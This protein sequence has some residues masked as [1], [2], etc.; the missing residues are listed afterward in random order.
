VRIS[1]ILRLRPIEGVWIKMEDDEI[2]ES[3]E[4]EFENIEKYITK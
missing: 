1:Q 2:P 4:E 3:A